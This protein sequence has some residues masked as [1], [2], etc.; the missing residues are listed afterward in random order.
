MQDDHEIVGPVAVNISTD[1]E[2]TP[3][4]QQRMVRF[5]GA[6]FFPFYLPLIQHQ[7]HTRAPQYLPPPGRQFEWQ[8]SRWQAPRQPIRY[9]NPVVYRAPLPARFS[10]Y[11]RAYQHDEFYAAQAQDGYNNEDMV[12]DDGYMDYYE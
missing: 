2:R 10:Q 7:H 3:P 12:V 6:I 11:P 4:A 9:A 8:G 5:L 1:V